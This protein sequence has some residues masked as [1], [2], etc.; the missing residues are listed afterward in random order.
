MRPIPLA[1][2]GLILAFFIITACNNSNY[3][4]HIYATRANKNYAFLNPKTTPFNTN[5]LGAF[6]GLKYF[7]PNPEFLVEAT[8]TWMENQSVFGFPHT[9]NKFYNYSKAAN[10][11]FNLNNQSYTLTGYVREGMQGDSLEIL[12]PFADLTNG[13]ETYA[14]GRYLDVW[15]NKNKTQSTLDF[16]L[17]YNPYCYYNA[18]YSCPITPKQNNLPIKINAGEKLMQ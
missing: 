2:L 12:I 16:N 3:N 11:K 7:E 6:K 13:T 10:F 18:D 5:D 8:V 17:A 15:L 14:G 9:Q 4:Q 1:H